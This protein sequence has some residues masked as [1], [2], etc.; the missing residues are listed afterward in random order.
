M[1]RKPRVIV[2]AAAVLYAVALFVAWH[3]FSDKAE[4]RVRT[5]LESAETGFAAVINGEIEAAL[6][7]VGG[8]LVNVF[9][10]ICAPCP[11]ERMQ[12]L[13]K[14]FNIDELNIVDRTGKAIASNQ[15]SVLGFDYNSHPLTREFMALTNATTSMV[16][17]PF[18]PGIANPEMVCQYYGLAFPQH[19]GFLQLGMTVKRLRQNMYSYSEAEADQILENWHFSV[20]GWYERAESDPAYRPGGMIRRWSDICGE[21]AVGRYFD[22]KDYRYLALLP[23]SYCYVQRNSAFAVTAVVLAALLAFFTSQPAMR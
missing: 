12:E 20:V 19:D 9:G 15:K 4:A 11:I 7:N 6:R 10:G 5:M 21:M 1:F 2:C 23:V 18:R 8:A 14:T 16:S 13:A 3:S 22:Y 17:Q